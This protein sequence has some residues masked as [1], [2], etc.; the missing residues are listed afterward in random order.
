MISFALSDDQRMVQETVRR[1]AVEEVRPRLRELDVPA[2]LARG[3]DG[4]GLALVDVPEELGGLGLGAVTAAL[5]HEELAYGDPGLATAL[6][7]PHFVPAALIELASPEQARRLLGKLGRGAIAWS[8][9]VGARRD[10]DGWLLD[11]EKRFVIN[12]GAADVTVVFA[13]GQAFA[14]EA[15]NPGLR[16]GP[17]A[18]W[19][20]LDAVRA[21]PV[22]LAACRVPEADRLAHGDDAA[23][24]RRFFARASLV[25]AARQVGLARAAY[26]TALA[27]TQDRKAFGKPVAHFQA[28]S[29]TLA[30][31]LMEVDSARWMVWRAAAELDQGAT[32]APVSVAKA[33]VHANQAAWRVADEAVQ[34][35]GGAGY[36]QDF[37]VEKWLRDTKVLAL[38]AGTDQLAQLAIAGVGDG[39]PEDVLQ[40]VVT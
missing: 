21:G 20:G 7:A 40:P 36:I 3:F 29:F 38:V 5:V 6:W 14:V 12:A 16:P 11:G 37:P 35:H 30:E 17:R 22:A 34:L 26:E 23:R 19:L 13:G 31:M 28:V 18:E 2:E 15:S 33:A 25:V 10:G 8:G 9:P 32:T 1:F 39:L 24:I 4:L 27:Y